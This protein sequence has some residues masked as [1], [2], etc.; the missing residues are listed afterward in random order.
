M[1]DGLLQPNELVLERS[2]VTTEPHARDWTAIG[3]GLAAALA[4]IAIFIAATWAIVV[5]V[6]ASA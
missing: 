3:V 2:A 4:L 6:E 1:S 5:L